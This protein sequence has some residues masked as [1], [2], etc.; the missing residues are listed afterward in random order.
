MKFYS[1]L[2]HIPYVVQ[3]LPVSSF[4]VALESDSAL[5]SWKATDD[6]AEPTAIS[7]G[8]L[9][10]TRIDDGAF[11]EGVRIDAKLENG[12]YSVSVPLES[13]HLY[14]FK[15]EAWNEGGRSFPSE[16][17]CAGI[18]ADSKGKVT[19]VNNFDRLSPPA[20]FDSGRYAGFDGRLDMGVPYVSDISYIGENYEFDR[21]LDWIDDDNPGFGAS[22][23]DFAGRKLAGNTFDFVSV[24][25]RTIMAA[26]YSFDSAS[27]DAFC[28][29]PLPG[30]GSVAVDLLC[31]KQVTSTVGR[32][33]VEDRYCVF[34]AALQETL[35]SYTSRGGNLLVSGAYIGT[36]VWSNIYPVSTDVAEKEAAQSFVEDVLGYRW[37]TNHGSYTHEAVPLENPMVDLDGCSL[38]ISSEAGGPV[39]C[40]ENPDGIVPAGDD[41]ATVL[42][43]TGNYVSAAVFADKGDYRVASFGFPLET[44][45]DPGMMNLIFF[46]SL[47][48]LNA[49]KQ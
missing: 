46:R 11:G 14:S 43:Y 44:V 29:G 17:L 23:S 4:A 37:L 15:L 27:R 18:S 47:E 34:P 20:W 19:V 39:Y 32:G 33:A 13:G 26:G 9:L 28:S 38:I 24:H 35:R 12:V 30:D 7:K 5:L 21:S 10:Y 16:V 49:R 42:R 8:F 22:W 1:D 41:A 6:P 40:V 3:P 48:F 25:G 2:Y 45:T 36:D 31:G